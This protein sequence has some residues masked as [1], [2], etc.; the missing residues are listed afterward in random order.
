MFQ[1]IHKNNGFMCCICSKLNNNMKT[2]ERVSIVDF[3]QVNVT[4]VHG[5]NS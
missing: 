2:P 4:W 1:E 3:E 5:A